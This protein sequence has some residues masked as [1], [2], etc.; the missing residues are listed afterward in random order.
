MNKND[1]FAYN[2]KNGCII[3]GKECKYSKVEKCSFFYPE[4]RGFPNHFYDKM[5]MVNAINQARAIVSQRR[6]NLFLAILTA[7][8]IVIAVIALIT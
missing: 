2:E 4:K 8:A 6:Y 1:C 5:N 7:V 3:F